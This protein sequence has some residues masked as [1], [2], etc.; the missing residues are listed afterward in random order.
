MCGRFL[1][2]CLRK[3]AVYRLT[4]NESSP[5][6]NFMK[7][8]LQTQQYKDLGFFVVFNNGTDKQ[9]LT[10]KKQGEDFTLLDNE[11]VIVNI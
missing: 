10:N 8:L 2:N 9:I 11:Y 5:L 7:E 1:P 3:E 4:N 6:I